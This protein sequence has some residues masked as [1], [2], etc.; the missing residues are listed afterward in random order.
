MTD[1]IK[2]LTDRTETTF[3]IRYFS[4]NKLWERDRYAVQ[5]CE[6]AL[7]WIPEIDGDVEERGWKVIRRLGTGDWVTRMNL[8][9]LVEY[10]DMAKAYYVDAEEPYPGRNEEAFQDLG[11]LL[12]L[13][14][15]H[16]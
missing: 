1:H 10:L 12:E 15:E 14:L 4:E 3:S 7:R 6:A 8:S 16:D 2:K 9:D 11:R 5:L 13:V